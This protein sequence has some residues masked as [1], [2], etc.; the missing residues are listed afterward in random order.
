MS[1]FPFDRRRFAVFFSILLLFTLAA[2]SGSSNDNDSDSIEGDGL[3][4]GS[5]SFLSEPPGIDDEPIAEASVLNNA[6]GFDIFREPH[7]A[8]EVTEE[9]DDSAE[10]A[11]FEAGLPQA[12]VTVPDGLDT[13]ANSAP[14]FSNLENLDVLAGERVSIRFLPEDADGNLPG[15]FPLSL[16]QGATFDDN[17]DGSK[18]F[19]WQPLQGNVGIFRLTVVAVDF[20]AADYRSAQ[21]VL[22]RISLPDDLSSIP[23]VAPTLADVADFT[24]RLNDAAV[25]ELSGE[26]LNGTTPTI[27]VPELPSG[28]SLTPH[29]RFEDVFVLKLNATQI[30]TN[31]VDILVRDS[32]DTGVT[33]L[34]T[35][36]FE[37][38]DEAAFERAG[39]A[40]R[41]LAQ[42]RDVS[43]GFAATQAFYHRPDG[44][45]YADTAAREFSLVK[46]EN[47]M[48]WQIINPLPG[49]YE[50]A[51]TDNLMRFARLHDMSVHGHA[52]IWY[53]VL[54]EWIEESEVGD[55][56]QHMLEFIERIMG[57]YATDVDIWDVVNEPMDDDGSLR[58]SVWLE[59]MG[60]EYIDLALTKARELDPTAQLL[61]NEFDIS[62]AGPKF[63]GLL[64]LI[65]R[66]QARGVPLDGIG[67]QMHVFSDF[68][69]FD[70]LADHLAAIADLDLDVY[71]T[72]LDVSIDGVVDT[73]SQARQA[74]V[75][76]QVASICLQQSRCKSLQM[77]G[78]TD[79][80]SFRSQFSPLL[81]DTAYQNKPA[82]DALL[83]ALQ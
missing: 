4:S 15:M 59:A 69:T 5:D 66:L 50:F 35:L 51:A 18:T 58:D 2:C 45:I 12:V 7:S 79:R 82:Y 9:I 77:W 37:V 41:D 38:Q 67:F 72:E 73:E 3:T 10:Q 13:T 25:F 30:G 24:V 39:A 19:N 11:E 28:A 78:F 68:S 64:A 47:S 65:Q 52:L 83:E 49:Q 42:N 44:V 26:D 6:A 70:D 1:I 33:T 40:L 34:E 32:A 81:F 80:Y 29:P 22:I 74:D 56:E 31:S 76:R 43:I 27:E 21:S 20:A 46:P 71:I 14:F 55:R 61:I 17:L 60:E 23:N 75:Y 16:P 54:P 63:D 48:K 8:I 53:T 36:D 62:M 57:R